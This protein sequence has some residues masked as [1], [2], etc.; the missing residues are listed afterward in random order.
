MGWDMSE[1]F[2]CLFTHRSPAFGC[3]W[4]LAKALACSW[5]DPTLSLGLT[6][7]EVLWGS[8]GLRSF[9]CRD[10]VPRTLPTF[11]PLALQGLGPLRPPWRLVLGSGSLESLMPHQWV[12]CQHPQLLRSQGCAVGSH[13]H[14]TWTLHFFPSTFTS[15]TRFNDPLTLRGQPWSRRPE[16]EAG[17]PLLLLRAEA[18][19]GAKLEKGLRHRTLGFFLPGVPEKALPL[20]WAGRGWGRGE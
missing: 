1:G 11:L 9:C 10:S 14:C 7:S 15:I 18:P 17:H 3:S 12:P 16:P 20:F 4:E 6:A 2:C 19:S 5:L 13:P 8:P